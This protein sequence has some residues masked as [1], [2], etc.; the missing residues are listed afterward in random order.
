[1]KKKF[2]SNKW[3][4]LD[5]VILKNENSEKINGTYKLRYLIEIWKILHMNKIF[6]KEYIFGPQSSTFGQQ[7]VNTVET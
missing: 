2:S 7:M 6:L 3:H 1:M 5:F 4:F